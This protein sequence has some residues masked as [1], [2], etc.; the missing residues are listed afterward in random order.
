ML[1]FFFFILVI[2]IL[3]FVKGARA[4]QPVCPCP[5]VRSA[6]E[7]GT[8]ADA[9]GRGC[10]RRAIHVSLVLKASVALTNS[11]IFYVT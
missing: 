4:A 3:I 6:P 10:S 8:D 7:R 2:I 1:F 5:G 11:W 9:P